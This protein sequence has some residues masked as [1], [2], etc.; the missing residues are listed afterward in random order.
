MYTDNYFSRFVLPED[1]KEALQKSRYLVY[2]ESKEELMEMAY[3]PTHSS[4]YDVCYPI[5]GKGC[6]LYTSDAADE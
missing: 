2:P 5:E 6:L 3:G 4:R 1:L